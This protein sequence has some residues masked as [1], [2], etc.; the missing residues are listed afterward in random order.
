MAAL[1]TIF[2]CELPIPGS[3]AMA[4]PAGFGFGRGS[5]VP[6]AAPQ[7]PLPEGWCAVVDPMG[8]T[9][10]ANPK[11]GDTTWVKPEMPKA[12]GVGDEVEIHGLQAK[13]QY[14]GCRAQVEGFDAEK[15]RYTVRCVNE[16]DT[17]LALKATNLTIVE[18]P[19]P[20]PAA[21]A[22]DATKQGTR[23][24]PPPAP[25]RGPL[26]PSSSS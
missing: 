10:Y 26:S 23:E 24:P 25:P 18:P 21:G 9:Y 5:G 20:P 16:E 14:N 1:A 15:D 22:G 4:T 2:S 3:R 8:R 6:P 11:T 13:P 19:P 7:S 12:I 17:V